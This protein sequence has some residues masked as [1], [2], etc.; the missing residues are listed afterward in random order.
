M[1]ELSFNILDMLR[2]R[3]TAYVTK[4][5]AGNWSTAVNSHSHLARFHLVLSGS[6]WVE[7]PQTGQREKLD[8]GDYVI[9]PNGEAHNLSAKPGLTPM[10]CDIIP[11]DEFAPDLLG[12]GDPSDGTHLLCGYFQMSESAPPAILTRLPNLLV[13]RGNSEPDRQKTDMLFQ[14]I[15]SELL[16]KSGNMPSVLNRISEILCIYAIQTWLEEMISQDL[17]LSALFDPKFQQVLDSIHADPIFPWT[18]ENLA[19]V[20]GQSRTTFA[21]HFRT[22]MGTAPINY[23]TSCRVRAAKRM[24]EESNLSLDEIADKSGYTDTN[25]FNRAFKRETGSAPGA[26]RRA[27]RR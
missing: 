7:L 2:I 5:P 23:V 20:F 1:T 8:K 11:S 27:S 26:F 4:N 14:L 21:T 15:R 24:L 25:A 3:S 10:A 12:Q 6:A 17:H 16:H 9:V 18:V 22:L 13:H 19:S